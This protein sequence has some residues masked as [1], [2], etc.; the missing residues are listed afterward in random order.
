MDAV[1]EKILSE[2]LA[3]P[4]E[5]RAELVDSLLVSLDGEVDEG[6]DEVWRAEIR[7]RV[8]DLDWGAVETI[9]WDEVQLSRSSSAVRTVFC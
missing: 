9:G 3:L 2:A 6:V 5:S 1:A 7:K 4:A 8:T